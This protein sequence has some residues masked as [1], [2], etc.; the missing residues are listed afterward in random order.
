MR[1]KNYWARGTEPK[2]YV[3][4]VVEQPE[5]SGTPSPVQKKIKKSAPK[6]EAVVEETV[7]T[8]EVPVAA[9]EQKSE[10]SEPEVVDPAA[11]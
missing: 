8:E 10:V 1:K 2:N 3:E 7:E 9:E 5:T 6:V 4:P 11:E